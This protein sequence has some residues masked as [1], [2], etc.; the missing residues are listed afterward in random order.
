M[1][2]CVQ[3]E[4]EKDLVASN[5]CY[6]GEVKDVEDEVGGGEGGNGKSELSK[7]QEG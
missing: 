5:L 1:S 7:K 2:S 4:E 3:E 6:R